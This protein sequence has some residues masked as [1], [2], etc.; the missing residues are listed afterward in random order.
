MKSWDLYSLNDRNK[1]MLFVC[2]TMTIV[3][4][5]SAAI[6]V[7]LRFASAILTAGVLLFT[8]PTILVWRQI[9]D[10][11]IM[12]YIALIF[13]IQGYLL[14]PEFVVYILTFFYSALISLYFD[15]RPVLIIGVANVVYTIYFVS[16]YHEAV[17]LAPDPLHHMVPLVSIHIL[18]TSLLTAQAIIGARLRSNSMM[19]EKLSKT[20]PLTGLY[21][22]KMF[23]EYLDSMLEELEDGQIEYL[24]VAVMDIDNFKHIN[25]TYGHST[26]DVIIT[27][28]AETISREKEGEDFAARYGGEEFAL[29][30]TDKPLMDSLLICERIRTSLMRLRHP[31]TGHE[32]VTVSIGLKA[33][34]PGMSSSELFDQADALLYEAK[35]SGKN[36]TVSDES[37]CPPGSDD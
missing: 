30:F 14:P 21:N 4:S 36:R 12:Y 32:P 1:F 5:I 20:D 25:D 31:E 34:K 9:L 13:S 10:R 27:R 3:G 24:Q 17:F 28:V 2:W 29:I 8:I 33:A 7:D 16:R 26:G 19:M 23:Y 35:R 6:A 15:Y 18:V 37:G 22:H 11:Y